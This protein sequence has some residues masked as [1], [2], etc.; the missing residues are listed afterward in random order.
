MDRL[1]KPITR[2]KCLAMVAGAAASTLSPQL[3]WDE[4]G[5]VVLR[6]AVSVETLA[7]ANVNDAR[8]AY[9][10]WLGELHGALGIV[11]AEP[12]PEIF[13]PSEELIRRVRQEMLDC[14]GVTALE[15]AKVA[16]LT[17]PDSLVIEDYLA[18]GMEYVLLV[19]NDSSFKKIADLRGAHIL[20]HL[21]RDMVLLPA[22]LGTML[23]SNSLPRADQFFAS[24]QIIGNLNQ[25]LLPVFFRRADGACM[26]RRSWEMA[27]ELNPQLGR[28]LRAVAVSPKVVPIVFAFRGNTSASA[29]K[30]LIDSIQHINT[31]PAGQQIVALYQSHGFIVKPI[32]VMK[33]TLEMVRQFDRLPEQQGH[34]RKGPA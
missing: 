2:R 20:S 28:E 33:N 25:A 6:L 9:R 10:I 29:R 17:D 13:I 26:A 21:H 18:G 23:A 15:L 24:H 22:W 14:Y 32:S 1:D 27:V 7:G 12:V 31:V 30:A 16:D 11:T 19:H 3:C 8:A 5:K 4:N 34:S